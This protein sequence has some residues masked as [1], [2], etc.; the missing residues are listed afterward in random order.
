MNRCIIFKYPCVPGRVTGATLYSDQVETAARKIF[1]DVVVIET[2]VKDDF[3]GGVKWLELLR[4]L[5]SRIPKA[6]F[7]LSVA[8]QDV[9]RVRFILSSLSVDDVVIFDHLRSTW[10]LGFFEK[11]LRNSDSTFL[12]VC[13][14]DELL[15]RRSFKWFQGAFL[16]N[17]V[18]LLDAAKIWFWEK[19]LI[20]IISGFTAISTADYHSLRR[21]F[22]IGS[23]FILPPPCEPHS[24]KR[25]RALSGIGN[26]IISGSF[27]WEY[28]YRDL[29]RFLKFYSSNVS[30]VFQLMVVGDIPE[31]RLQEL[32]QGFPGVFFTG[33]VVDVE[34]YLAKGC[35][36]LVIDNLGGGFKLKVLDYL[37]AEMVVYARDGSIEPDIAA[38]ANVFTWK[39]H[40]DISRDLPSVVAVA[41]SASDDILRLGVR[42]IERQHSSNAFTDIL[43]RGIE[44]SAKRAGHARKE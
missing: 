23:S 35:V 29:L 18:S 11:E 42:Y 43:A 4:I 22:K 25:V 33:K 36:G 40:A 27:H 32:R 8:S 9:E 37:K 34:P 19:R 44:V 38:L 17:I 12:Y 16:R 20:R 7:G 21:R 2:S 13:H 30:C 31:S 24:E 10:P 26:V 41:R 1:S 28:K 6:I 39:T 15:V 14:N 3:S 5:L